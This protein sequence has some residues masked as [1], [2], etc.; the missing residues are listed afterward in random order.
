MISEA[1]EL[2]EKNNLS[3][4]EKK[5]ISI[6]IW[7]CLENPSISYITHIGF[8]NK[9]FIIYYNTKSGRI[10]N[11]GFYINIELNKEEENEVTISG[12]SYRDSRRYREIINLQTDSNEE[13]FKEVII[14]LINVFISDY[15]TLLK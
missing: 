6:Y 11:G 13:H 8:I 4:T 9:D 14:Y 12:N 3:I 15:D 7:A 5:I 1:N 2:L 10:K